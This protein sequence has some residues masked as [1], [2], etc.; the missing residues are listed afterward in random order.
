MSSAATADVNSPQKGDAS[1]A[2][3]PT[4]LKSLLMW[5]DP[6]KSGLVAGTAFLTLFFFGIMNYT[7]LTFVCRAAQAVMIVFS[8]AAYLGKPMATSEQIVAK[9]KELHEAYLPSLLQCVDA[10]ARIVTWE[11][12]T[13]TMEVMVAS[14]LLAMLG[15]VFS[16]LTLIFLITLAFFVV[17]TLYVHNRALVDGQLDQIKQILDRLLQQGAEGLKEACVSL[18]PNRREQ[19]LVDQERAMAGGAQAGAASPARGTPARSNNNTSFLESTL[20]GTFGGA[21]DST[22]REMREGP[23]DRKNK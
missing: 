22:L 1:A 10:A 9:A 13:T 20:G 7:I 21:L 18:S 6:I 17:P 16:D 2:S 4:T 15:N 3:S 23:N 12:R 8:V 19:R 14:L 11:N 5:D